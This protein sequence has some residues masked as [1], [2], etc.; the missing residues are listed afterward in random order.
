M[1]KTNFLYLS[2]Y[3]LVGF[4]LTVTTSIHTSA[5]TQT[6]TQ[7][8]SQQNL[9]PNPQATNSPAKFIYPTQGIISQ[10][11]RKYQ[12][13]GIDIANASGTPILAVAAG[14][15]I[16]AGW[17]DWGLGYV[18]KIQHPNGQTTV[19]GHNSRLLVNQGQQVTQGQ[20]I[21]Q[22]GSTGNSSAPHLHFEIH[23][24]QRVA[25][26]PIEV[27]TPPNNT[28]STVAN[29]KT[30]QNTP[31]QPI[32]AANAANN[33]Q[34][35][36]PPNRCHGKTLIAGETANA[37]VQV[38]QE[39]GQFFYI[40]ELKQNPHQVVKLPAWNLNNLQYRADNGSFSYFVTP[41]GVEVWRNGSRFRRDIFYTNKS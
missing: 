34:S 29:A 32:S 16:K 17:D 10:S 11:F 39:N 7:N 14:K 13:E 9:T 33:V 25:V 15:V 3:G 6:L 28:T 22:M 38:C 8:L 1:K 12:H 26:N 31:I 2:T 27:L 18:V 19:Y 35:N 37:R 36:N 23:T 4:I 40:G 20:I 41:Q 24:N 5:K 21:A 30:Q